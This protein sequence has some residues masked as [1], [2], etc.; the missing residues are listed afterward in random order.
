M[1]GGPWRRGSRRRSSW[2]HQTNASAGAARKLAGPQQATG[3][4]VATPPATD[5]RHKNY[6]RS[7]M[8]CS[9]T[10]ISRIPGRFMASVATEPCATCDGRLISIGTSQASVPAPQQR[11]HSRNQSCPCPRHAGHSTSIGRRSRA[12]P[13]R[14]ACCGL[15]TTRT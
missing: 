5:L 13:P 1:L 6:Q 7:M 14:S 3:R 4:G 15:K 12:R 2:A 11:R 10:G 8:K 9:V